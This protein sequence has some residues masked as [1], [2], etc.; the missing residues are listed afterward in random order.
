MAENARH[1]PFRREAVKGLAT[2]LLLLACN[3]TAFGSDPLCASGGPAPLKLRVTVP[4]AHLQDFINLLKR[5]PGEK[6][7]LNAEH[8]GGAESE[9]S[10]TESYVDV[11]D[12]QAEAFVTINVDHRRS[13]PDFDFTFKTCNTEAS[14]VPYLEALRDRV[15]EFAP[16]QVAS[17]P[18]D[19]TLH[20]S[21]QL[22]PE[23]P[24]E[25]RTVTAEITSDLATALSWTLAPQI[26]EE[27]CRA[28]DPE[29]VN[30]RSDQVTAWRDRNRALLAD[31]DTRVAEVVPLMDPSTAAAN[32]IA[33]VRQRVT[34][35]LRREL[36][37]ASENSSEC[38]KLASSDHPFWHE[39]NADQVRSSLV[40]LQAWQ[41]RHASLARQA[42]TKQTKSAKP[43]ELDAW[44]AAK[45]MGIG[46]NIGNTLE[47]TTRWET[48][49]GNPRI[50]REFIDSLAAMGFRTVRV[51]VAWDTYAMDGKFPPDKMARVAEVV[52]WILDAGMYCVINIHWDG[53]WI[54][55]SD[56]KRFARTYATFSSDAERK[57]VSYWTQIANHFK[58]RNERLVFE[59]LNEETHFEGAGSM[60]DAYATLARV[61]QLFIDT[62]RATG[63]NNASRLLVI[64]GYNTDI[65]RTTHP[66]YTLPVDTVPS[67]LLLSVHYYTPW[68]F[69]GM[70]K[71]E[72][73]GKVQHTW[74]S[75]A[76]LAVLERL[77]NT[78]QEFS[79]RHDIPVFVG[80]FGATD[81]K[82]R[83]SRVRW[84]T[85]VA[86]A[87]LSRNMVPVL[88]DTGGD[89]ARRPP[90]GPSPALREVL[91]KVSKRK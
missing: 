75:S 33:G 8:N 65:A 25:L 35:I 44:A 36:G 70:N 74:G 54:D 42:N 86:E 38:E 84:M 21:R 79:K 89:L 88:W 10:F 46:V 50:T 9:D 71:D 30:G 64:A 6:L 19:D 60:K 53:G 52:D 27:V 58:G 59:G 78:M 37:R 57:F 73:W 47:N 26:I 91:Q 82:E 24:L 68:S 40:S 18:T 80:E 41:A 15:R 1:A 29:R 56:K 12:Y 22:F 3:V 34:Q 5:P 85:A 2:L 45:A 77:F 4:E 28:T 31:V 90:F 39:S 43:A 17:M 67:R 16:V 76:D 14:Y 48:G 83:P 13:S 11:L 55:S 81:Q 51:P 7:V 62:V 49:W 66:D 61:N 32:A 23:A 20:I 87:A 63:G 72:T 69:A